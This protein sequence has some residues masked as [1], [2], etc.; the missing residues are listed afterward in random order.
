MARPAP[1]VDNPSGVTPD[2]GRHSCIVEAFDATFQAEDACR[3]RTRRKSPA[4]GSEVVI[5]GCGEGRIRDTEG[6][7]DRGDAEEGDWIGRPL[8]AEDRSDP[9]TDVAFRAGM[10]CRHRTHREVDTFGS[11][12]VD[13]GRSEAPGAGYREGG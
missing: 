13:E 5:E 1:Y 4:P 3:R 8:V 7:S 9:V 11:E 10:A 12:P 6:E 2:G